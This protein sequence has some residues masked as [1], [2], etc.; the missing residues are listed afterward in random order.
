MGKISVCRKAVI[1]MVAVAKNI[2]MV[3]KS[4]ETNSVVVGKCLVVAA[5]KLKNIVAVRSLR[6]T[7][8]SRMKCV[9]CEQPQ[10]G[11]GKEETHWLQ[12]LGF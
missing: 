11:G 4:R 6:E 12:E 3:N 10:D 2:A 9:M 7:L 1:P 8:N 5:L